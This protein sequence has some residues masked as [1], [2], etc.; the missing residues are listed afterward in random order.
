VI[1]SFAIVEAWLNSHA[2]LLVS[3]GVFGAATVGFHRRVVRPFAASVKDAGDTVREVRDLLQTQLLPNGGGK[4]GK[5][6][7]LRDDLVEI[8]KAVVTHYEVLTE[9]L[10]RLDHSNE[11][12]AHAEQQVASLGAQVTQLSAQVSAI[13]TLVN[14]PAS[15]LPGTDG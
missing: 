8:G 13:A 12:F 15:A 10:Q 3:L 11:R 7:N 2:E 1:A 4:D 14:V 5:P 6:T 9:V